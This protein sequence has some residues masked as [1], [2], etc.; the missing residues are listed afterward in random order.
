MLIIEET[1]RRT[2]AYDL[3]YADGLIGAPSHDG[4]EDETLD[5]L[6]RLG[7]TDAC[8]DSGN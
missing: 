1:R 8:E 7:F 3:G 2:A 6:Y 4:Y 5:E